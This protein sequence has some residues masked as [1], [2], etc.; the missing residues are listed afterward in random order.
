MYYVPMIGIILMFFAIYCFK[1]SKDWKTSLAIFGIPCLCCLSIMFVLGAFYGGIVNGTNDILIYTMN[2]NSFINPIPIDN[3][4]R[5]SL[6]LKPLPVDFG[7]Y[8]GGCYLGLGV[9]AFLI[10]IIFVNLIIRLKNKNQN[11][12][13]NNHIPYQYAHPLRFYL[14]LMVLVF[15]I[16]SLGTTVKLG[17]IPITNIW[18]PQFVL[19]I[20]SIFRSTGRFIWPV[21]YLIFLYVIVKLRE[22]FQD[23]KKF[24][25]VVCL[26][27]VVNLIDYSG[28]LIDY[29]NY[30]KQEFQ[31]QTHL[32]NEQWE[33][34]ENKNIILLSD[35]Q[36]D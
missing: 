25:L 16:L 8:E 10:V 22:I 11:K 36:T 9:I 21:Y 35:F 24:T 2:I 18:Y 20:L 27:V 23:N 19:K 34:I 14:M 33:N 1:E 7:Q 31:R 26:T 13:K 4:G 6:L 29:H 12:N 17:T 28:M 3:S 15:Y 5:V 30:Y 32:L